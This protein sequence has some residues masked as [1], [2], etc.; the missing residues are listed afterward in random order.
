MTLKN[1]LY[2]FALGTL[3]VWPEYQITKNIQIDAGVNIGLT[4]SANDW[5]PFAGIS[6]RF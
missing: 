1:R 6:F 2:M 3:D 4:D 5:N